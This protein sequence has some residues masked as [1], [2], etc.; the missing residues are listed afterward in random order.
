M[1]GWR[2]PGGS[3]PGGRIHGT[4]PRP[5][6]HATV[7]AE[8]GPIIPINSSD[9]GH[10]M[11]FHP[12][13]LRRPGA[14]VIALLGVLLLAGCG[15]SSTSAPSTSSPSTAAGTSTP[16][17]GTATPAPAAGTV[18]TTC[19]T[20]AEIATLTGTTFPAPQQS[21]AT[22]TLLCSYNDTTSGANLVIEFASAPG[23]TAS[24]LETAADAAASAYSVTPSSISGFGDAAY[25]F[26]GNDASTNASGVATT[27][28]TIL[29][30]S[31]E[32]DITAELTPAEVQAV[33]TYVLAHQ[34]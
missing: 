3:A 5:A 9:R 7:D 30:G 15:A 23:V 34:G 17:S 14:G 26:T 6:K 4:D 19:A 1:V 31:E 24:V 12:P 10:I 16:S 25:I 28:L 11:S 22:G 13:T 33:A 18:P 8:I 2:R 27:V 21:S 20:P 32:I 29:D